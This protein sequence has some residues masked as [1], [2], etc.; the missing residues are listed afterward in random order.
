[1][2][3]QLQN[4]LSRLIEL[5]NYYKRM[6][7]NLNKLYE[8]A[9]DAIGKDVSP[10][11]FAPDDL[12]CVESYCEVYRSAFGIYPGG[13]ATPFLNT[14]ALLNWM[15]TSPLFVKTDYPEPGTT[16]IVVTEFRGGKTIHGHVGIMGDQ[17]IMSND[18]R[19]GLW[20]SNYTLPVWNDFFGRRL[21]LQIYYFNHT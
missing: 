5:L 14:I 13:K 20:L 11:D 12:A 21:K 7:V 2:I 10:R 1:M 4:L 8:A 16:I 19:Y 6:N 3:Q 17:S 15:S 18:S 9:K